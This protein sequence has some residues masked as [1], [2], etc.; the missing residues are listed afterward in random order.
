MRQ[1][2]L[3]M[4]SYYPQAKGVADYA[5]GQGQTALQQGYDTTQST[6]N[7]FLQ[8][9][10]L[11][12]RTAPG[13]S[14]L[15]GT[16]RSDIGNTVNS[17]FAGAG[18]DL[19]GANV[20]ALGRG[21]TQGEAP[22]LLNQYNQNVATQMGALGALNAANQS[23]VAGRAALGQAGL[24]TAQSLPDFMNAPQNAL[25][26]V[27]N[28]RRM[29]PLQGLGALSSLLLPLAGMGGST[30]GNAYT[31]GQSQGY[32]TQTASPLQQMQGWTQILGNLLKLPGMPGGGQ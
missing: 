14:D 1:N 17:Q 21:I 31:R 18:R 22:V 9:S 20:G 28:M 5:L 4:P 10:Y 7:P 24:S 23:T 19:S 2:A 15:L 30:Q 29:L 3:S 26:N 6:L 12:P 16:V 25:L 13:M 8:S 32:G 11:D 27:E